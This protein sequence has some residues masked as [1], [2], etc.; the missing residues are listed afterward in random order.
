MT[1]TRVSNIAYVLTS[2]SPPGSCHHLCDE[3]QRRDRI[4]FANCVLFERSNHSPRLL[5]YVGLSFERAHGKRRTELLSMSCSARILFQLRGKNRGRSDMKPAPIKAGSATF[6][7]S[8]D[9][10]AKS[11]HFEAAGFST[12]SSG[13]HHTSAKQHAYRVLPCPA[14]QPRA[15]G[16]AIEA[17]TK[18]LR[19]Q[20]S[21]SAK[22]EKR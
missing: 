18:A 3:L 20:L 10:R 22:C 9:S 2:A 19:S 16:S 15:F 14:N 7:Q 12:P 1:N 17:T 21:S 13:E 8:D 5:H 11:N 6:W 4:E